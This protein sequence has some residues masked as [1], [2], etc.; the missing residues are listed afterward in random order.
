M[1]QRIA[2]RLKEH[3]AQ[4]ASLRE[5]VAQMDKFELGPR[6][7]VCYGIGDDGIPV[8]FV[9]IPEKAAAGLKPKP[10]TRRPTKAQQ[11]VT[12]QIQA[13]KDAVAA[14][15]DV[16]GHVAP[17]KGAKKTVRLKMGGQRA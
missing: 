8:L 12:D 5:F 1:P 11:A 9:E 4:A 7:K 10:G 13:R 17:V 2:M 15:E 6:T 16:P 3:R 14:K